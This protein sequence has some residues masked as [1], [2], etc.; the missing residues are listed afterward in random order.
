MSPSLQVAD[1]VVSAC[2]Q[3]LR[4]ATA[5]LLDLQREQGYW[6]ADLTADTTLESDFILLELRSVP[7]APREH[8]LSSRRRIETGICAHSERFRFG[9]GSHLDRSS[10]E[11]SAGGRFRVDPASFTSLFGNRSN[12]RKALSLAFPRTRA[13]QCF[14]TA[15][16]G[17]A[18]P[19]VQLRN[20]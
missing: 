13:L 3:A 8:S 20:C 9:R 10:G 11:F 6:W 4:R 15:K 1:P 12:P 19:G 2:A 18:A 17:S 14:S 7:G 5:Y 16:S